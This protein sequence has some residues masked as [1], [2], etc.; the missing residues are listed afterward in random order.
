MRRPAPAAVIAVLARHGAAAA[1]GAFVASV[2]EPPTGARWMLLALA[3]SLT[4][5]AI[6]AHR[7]KRRPDA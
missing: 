7:H 2:T 3:I 5:T 4:A 1:G 6:T